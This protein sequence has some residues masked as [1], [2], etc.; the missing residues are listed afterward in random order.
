MTLP[1]LLLLGKKEYIEAARMH[2]PPRGETIGRGMKVNKEE[3]LGML[4]A[5]A[6]YL[7]K[8]HEKEW[9][10]WKAQIELISNSVKAVDGVFTE[11]HVPPHANHVPSL[12]IQWDERKVKITP[13]AVREQL[14][15][16]HP[17][18]QTVGNENTIGITTWMMT[19]G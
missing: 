18:I 7:Q 16:G 1:K 14:R 3:V 12:R 2:T 9:Q 13:E 10:L 19:P 17:S 8:D 5:L 11:I 15:E 6:L 4:V